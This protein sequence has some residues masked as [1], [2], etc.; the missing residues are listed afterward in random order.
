MDNKVLFTI[1]YIEVGSRVRISKLKTLFKKDYPPN[2]TS[3]LF[4]VSEVFR[5]RPLTYKLKDDSGEEKEGSFYFYELQNVG[6]KSIFNFKISE[7]T[8]T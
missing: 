7:S 4:T 3:E 5:T 2:K 6:E 8:K 1:Y